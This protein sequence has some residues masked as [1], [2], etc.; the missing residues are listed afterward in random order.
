MGEQLIGHISRDGTA[1]EAHEHSRSMVHVP[2]IDH[3]PRKGEKI[4][5]RIIRLALGTLLY[6]GILI[7]M[8]TRFKFR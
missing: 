6:A 8:F 3:T 7:L 2:L 1:I 4:G 5:F